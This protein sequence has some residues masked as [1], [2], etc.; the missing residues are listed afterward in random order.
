MARVLVNV[1]ANDW[2]VHFIAPDGRTR[3]RPWLLLDGHD[4]VLAI[5][6]WGNISA[7]DLAEHESSLR[8]WN[9]SSVAL[10]LS[11]TQIAAL[12]ERGR[13][14]PWNGYE[15]VQMR[16]AER[17]PPKRL[18]SRNSNPAAQRPIPDREVIEQPPIHLLHPYDADAMQASRCDPLVGSV[19]NNGPEMLNS[20]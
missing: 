4:E 8:R 9:V 20:A 12:I 2:G 3:I 16:K 19:R 17:Y 15:L 13:G 7:F 6:R 18:L 5:L 1:T 10:D 11:E 14:W